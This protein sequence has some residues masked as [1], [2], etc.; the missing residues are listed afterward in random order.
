L[1]AHLRATV[2][3]FI[4]IETSGRASGPSLSA[5][6]K[7]RRWLEAAKGSVESLGHFLLLI[8]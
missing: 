4:P 7:Q 6:A 2:A 5:L 8:V 3:D 1:F